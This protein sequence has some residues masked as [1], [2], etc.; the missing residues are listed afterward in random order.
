VQAEGIRD[1]LPPELVV[2]MVQGLD[3]AIDRWWAE[4]PEA[5]TAEASAAFASLKATVRG[6]GT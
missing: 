6:G 5:T 3:G 1:D 4:H 2:A